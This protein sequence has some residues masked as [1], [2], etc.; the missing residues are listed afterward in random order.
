MALH[1]VCVVDV[2]QFGMCAVLA[3]VDF[4]GTWLAST[5]ES[6]VEVCAIGCTVKPLNRGHFGDNIN[7]AHLF[8]D[9]SSL[10]GSNV[11]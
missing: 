4:S 9:V 7:S 5:V 1:Q 10:G 8:S 3:W 2:L 11:L 6:K